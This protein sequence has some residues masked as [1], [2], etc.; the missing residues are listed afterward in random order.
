PWSYRLVLLRHGEST[1]NRDNRYIGWTD[2]PLTEKGE[3]EAREAGRVLK[4][5]GIV[6]V[7]VYTSYLKRAIKTAWIAL[8]SSQL[9]YLPS[10]ATGELNERMWGLAGLTPEEAYGKYTEETVKQWAKSLSLAPPPVEPGSEVDPQ[11]EERY[12][13]EWRG[14]EREGGWPPRT[15]SF[16]DT[17][18]RAVGYWRRV[19]RP[20]M[21]ERRRRRDGGRIKG[22][23]TVLVVSHANLIRS[24]MAHLDDV[25]DAEDVWSFEVPRAVPIV[26][27]FDRHFRPLRTVGGSSV[28]N[29]EREE[30]G[31]V[32]PY[33]MT[34]KFLWP[35]TEGRE[36]GW[37]TQM[38]SN[39]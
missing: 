6:P 32:L 24:F 20:Y 4:E 39:S 27:H 23:V 11:R 22:G 25:R 9:T 29:V 8:L 28:P 31:V 38:T 2:V 3:E 7:H 33:K 19:M 5:H 18:R 12:R 36:E 16:V 15:E 14:G 13:G 37:A 10:T 21:E 30:G 35:Q 26:Y 34:S 17:Q 1:W